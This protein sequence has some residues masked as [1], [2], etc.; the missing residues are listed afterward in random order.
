MKTTDERKKIII[1]GA[2]IGGLYVAGK[3][4]K[5]G[6]SVTVY[7]KKQREE[8]GYPWSDSVDKDTFRKAAIALPKDAYTNK[9]VLKFYSPSGYGHISQAQRAS[10]NFDVDRKKL[11]EYLICNAENHCDI[12]FG[13]E[14]DALT[15]DGDSVTGVTVNGQTEYC[16]LVIDSAGIFSKYRLQLPHKFFM[17]DALQ[18]H[19]YLIAYR[20]FYKKTND[21]PAPSNV[22]LMPDGFSVLWCK[23]AEDTSLSDVFISNF[24]SLDSAQIDAAFEYIRER[25]PHITRNCTTYAQDAIPV[26][27]PFATI[28]AN[29]YALIGNAAFM[30]KP[31][32][33]S[34]IENTLA[35]AVILTD[36]IKKASD[37]SAASLWQYAVKVNNAF[38]ANC[39]MAY[40]ARSRF[41]VLNR[42]DL[43]WLFDSGILN[44][45]LLAIA[46]FDIRSQDDFQLKNIVDSLSLARSK[47]E[48]IK[49]IGIILRKCLKA[50]ILASRMPHIYD[51]T[52]IK[53]WKT[54]YDT[55]A[56]KN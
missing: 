28:V 13:T 24:T 54:E 11:I 20:G 38:G 10:K 55:F 7:E 31:T 16:D 29:G 34:G 32:S 53:A 43:I 8:L 50:K 15:L 40:I 44:E 42:E 33:G 49:Q 2:G 48:F 6:F 36:V 56:R 52:A 9:Q 30:T 3:L 4:G 51:E 17:N 22:Y 47:P 26:R 46:R 18:P 25:N 39:Y 5:L 35:A 45:S 37:F 23:D 1:L 41:Q 27:Y 12:R 19:D 14:A 21:L